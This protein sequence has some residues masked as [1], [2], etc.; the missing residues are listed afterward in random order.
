MTL[1]EAALHGYLAEVEQDAIADPQRRFEEELK[2]SEHDRAGIEE[3]AIDGFRFR[4]D[5]FELGTHPERH[6]DIPDAWHEKPFARIHFDGEAPDM[7]AGG[8]GWEGFCLSEGQAGTVLA[9]IIAAQSTKQQARSAIE[10]AIDNGWLRHSDQCVFRFS[11]VDDVALKRACSCGLQA[12]LD[13]LDN[14]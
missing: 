11:A 3:R 1:I 8:G 12:F 6:P 13:G 4:K 9:D 2:Y 5:G 10:T 7:D 14:V